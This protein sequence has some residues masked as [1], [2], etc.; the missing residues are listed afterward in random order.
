MNM[1]SLMRKRR[2]ASCC[3]Y[4]IMLQKSSQWQRLSQLCCIQLETGSDSL[5]DSRLNLDDSPRV[6]RVEE[7][8]IE[9]MRADALLLNSICRLGREIKSQCLIFLYWWEVLPFTLAYCTCELWILQSVNNPLSLLQW[10]NKTAQQLFF[11]SI[12]YL[13]MY[14]VGLARLRQDCNAF[15]GFTGLGP[16]QQLETKTVTNICGPSYPDAFD[17]LILVTAASITPQNKVAPSML[18]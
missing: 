6:V 3:F 9:V 13:K 4:S 16:V 14:I 15:M 12:S 17:R 8:L 11:Y 1:S 7:H 2:D 5:Y 10:K 18:K